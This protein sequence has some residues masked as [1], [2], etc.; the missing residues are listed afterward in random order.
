MRM[1][2]GMEGQYHALQYYH[3]MVFSVGSDIPKPHLCALGLAPVAEQSS[4]ISMTTVDLY[5]GY[6]ER[7]TESISGA[8]YACDIQISF[9]RSGSE[10]NL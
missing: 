7:K 3:L 5:S 2:S 6:K 4:F 8:V 10:E 9:M 1:K